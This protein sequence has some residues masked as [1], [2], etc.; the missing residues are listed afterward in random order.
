M[1]HFG[2]FVGSSDMPRITRY[3]ICIKFNDIPIN[4]IHTTRW[5]IRKNIQFIWKWQVIPHGMGK[6]RSRRKTKYWLRV[7]LKTML[8]KV[9]QW[10]SLLKPVND[11]G[12]TMT[13]AL[14]RQLVAIFNSLRP[15]E[16]R[17]I[18]RPTYEAQCFIVSLLRMRWV[19]G[20][21]NTRGIQ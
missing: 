10:W 16:T 9:V 17:Y 12:S 5:N 4:N 13:M 6:H 11:R 1:P 7:T 8:V 2:L 15:P 18:C 20:S 19:G 3:K 14:R 21:F